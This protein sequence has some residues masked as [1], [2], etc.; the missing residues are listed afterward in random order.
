[1]I[2]PAELKAISILKNQYFYSHY[3]TALHVACR[4]NNVKVVEDILSNEE[5]YPVVK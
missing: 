3:Q 1:M 5:I 2:L 4:V